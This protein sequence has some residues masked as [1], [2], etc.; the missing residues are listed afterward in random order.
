L[1]PV[2][3]GGAPVA[4]SDAEPPLRPAGTMKAAGM[5]QNASGR[6]WKRDSL[7]REQKRGDKF[8]FLPWQTS[9][10][11]LIAIIKMGF[12]KLHLKC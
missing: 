11:A 8:E 10:F 5:G 12:L 1:A 9:S 4:A 6:R 2:P 3:S 7:E